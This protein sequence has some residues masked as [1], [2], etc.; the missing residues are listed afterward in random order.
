M[1]IGSGSL[2]L[3]QDDEAHS[4]EMMAEIDVMFLLFII[5]IEFSLKTLAAIQRIIFIGGGVQVGLTILITYLAAQFFGFSSGEAIMLGFLFSLSSI[6]IVLKV[7]QEKKEESSPHGKITLAIL[8][9][10]GIIVVLIMLFTPLIA[11]KDGDV[12][13]ALSN[14]IF[15]F[16]DIFVWY[17]VKV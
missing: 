17:Y 9:F 8:I 7:L 5:G 1:I 3:I 2:R 15:K 10:Q 14:L 4:V 11:G 13:Q 6:A 12:V 16:A